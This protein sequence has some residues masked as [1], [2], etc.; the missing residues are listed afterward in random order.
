MTTSAPAHTTEDDERQKRPHH[1]WFKTRVTLG[2]IIVV[3]LIA[4]IIGAVTPWPSAMVIRAVF[5][6]GGDATAAEMDEYVPDTPLTE[7]LDV[8]YADDGA[9]TTMDVFT[10]AS[11]SG[12]LPTIVW[13]H[14]GA[15]ISGSKENVDPYLRILAAEGY[16]TIGVNYTLGPEGV[17]PTAVGQLNEALSYIDAHADELNVDASQIVLAGD[18][19][20]GQL[21]SQMATIMTSP[22][23]AEILSVDPALDADQVVATV[24]NCGVY[25]LSALAALDGIAGWGLKSAMWAYAGTKTWAENATGATMSTIDWVTADFPTT[26]ISGGNGDGL[27]WLQSI[28]MAQRLDELG[29]DVTTQ[30]WPAAHEPALPH[31]YQFH[32]DMPDARTA[33]Q[34]TIDF[35]DAHTD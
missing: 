35:L 14:G 8:A 12:P 20:G 25:D 22:D 10:P 16:T 5:T 11:A 4:A 18:S 1:R 17:Y 3:L 28:P 33:L 6:Q 32:L 26:Y 23:Y 29:V 30:F 27:T 21:A 9:D 15:W 31:E 2:I 24:L 13:I 7:T 19:A 34:M